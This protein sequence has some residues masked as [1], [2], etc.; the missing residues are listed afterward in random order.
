M[1]NDGRGQQSRTALSGGNGRRR[2]RTGGIE[3]E[4]A[5]SGRR[6]PARVGAV[7]NDLRAALQR[8]AHLVGA[9]QETGHGQVDVAA[10]R[11]SSGQ[12]P[13]CQVSSSSFINSFFL[14]NY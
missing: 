6:E 9:D 13:R 4:R 3:R 8:A 14:S 12:S 2:R 11:G 5:E 10:R 7:G 1:V